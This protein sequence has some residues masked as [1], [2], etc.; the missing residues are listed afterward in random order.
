[1][2]TLKNG[3]DPIRVNGGFGGAYYFRKSRDE[4]LAI[5]KPTDEEPFAPNNNSKRFVGKVL[6]QPGFKR[7]QIALNVPIEESSLTFGDMVLKNDLSAIR[8][9]SPLLLTINLMH[10]SS[11]TSC[12]SPSCRDIQNKDRSGHINIL[13]NSSSFL[14]TKEVVKEIMKTLK[15]GV[16]PIRVNGGFG[17]AYYFRKSRDESLA[18]VKPTD[19]EPFAPNNNSKRFVGKVLGQP[20]FKRSVRVREDPCFHHSSNQKNNNLGYN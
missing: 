13:G 16:D 9:D 7:L 2:K 8:N 17:G 18:I 14:K 12:L 6:G 1:M 3:V 5:V 19:E 15:N 11:S 4:S 20:G 10:R